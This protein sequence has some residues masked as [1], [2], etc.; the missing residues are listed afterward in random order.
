MRRFR[1]LEELQEQI[2]AEIN[3]KYLGET[4]EVL[5][6]EKVKEPLEGTHP[7]EQ[8]GLRRIG[9]GPERQDPARHRHLDGTVVHAG[10]SASQQPDIDHSVERPLD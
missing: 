7:H 1:M 8:T 3:K 9:R 2:V 10:E 6:E 5:F 4:V